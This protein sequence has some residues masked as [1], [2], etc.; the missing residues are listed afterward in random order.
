MS[1]ISEHERVTLDLIREAWPM[2][3]PPRILDIGANVGE[4]TGQV[5][6]C[7]P[8]AIVY[9]YEPQPEARRQFHERFDGYPAVQLSHYGLS[10][11]P[12]AAHLRA[13]EHGACV[14]ATMYDRPDAESYHGTGL[15]L[16][17]RERITLETVDRVVPAGRRFT[18]MKI[19]VEGHEL[20]VLIGA[21]RTLPW[22]DLIQF[23]FNDCAGVAGIS[24]SDLFEYLTGP[25]T[26][27]GFRLYQ[28]HE[29]GLEL[30][31][32]P[33]SHEWTAGDSNRDYLAVS[34]ECVWWPHKTRAAA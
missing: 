21:A 16:D 22:I 32:E 10:S 24:F 6:R 19:D 18:I 7:W 30:V 15:K 3:L 12:G 8:D 11:S 34:T 2:S 9:A 27:F 13:S 5:L 14:L 1:V 29:D 28:E 26:R 31:Q 25:A 20:D 33:S 17:R 4:W 23:E